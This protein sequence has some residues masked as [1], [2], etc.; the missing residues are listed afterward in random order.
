M[1]SVWL[2]SRNDAIGNVAVLL[3]A[4]GVAGTHT[5]WPDLAVAVG[6]GALALTSAYSVLRQARGEM[7]SQA[8]A[9]V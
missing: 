6:M 7:Q 1:R 9:P 8:T 2:C 5:A 3:A 4:L